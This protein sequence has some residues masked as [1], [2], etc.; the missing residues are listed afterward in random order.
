MKSQHF[1]VPAP[2]SN[3]TFLQTCFQGGTRRIGYDDLEYNANQLR[4]AMDSYGIGSHRMIRPPAGE[5][6]LHTLELE[7][8]ITS[9]DAARDM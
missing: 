7:G 1:S 9:S 2:A 8:D 5:R 3:W 6:Q 4:L